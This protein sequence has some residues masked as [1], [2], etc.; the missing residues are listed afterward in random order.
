MASEFNSED[1]GMSEVVEGL[2]GL[3]L[4]PIVLTLRAGVNQP[5]VQAAIKEGVALSERCQEAIVETRERFE[6]LVVEAQAGPPHEGPRGLFL[7][8]VHTPPYCWGH[9]SQRSDFPLK[10]SFS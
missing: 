3:I 1:V 7:V 8:P 2:K 5:P 6:D 10:S 9:Q 4:A